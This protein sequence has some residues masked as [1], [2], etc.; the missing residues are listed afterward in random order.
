MP[1]TWI[2]WLILIVIVLWILHNPAH[3]GTTVS[4]AAHNVATFFSSATSNL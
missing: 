3:A 2:G 4:N 1:K